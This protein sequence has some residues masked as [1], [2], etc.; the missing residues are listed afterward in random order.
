VRVLV[1]FK[2]NPTDVFGFNFC[3]LME[4]P[5]AYCRSRLAD[6]KVPKV[7]HI[8]SALPKTATGKVQRRDLAALFKPAAK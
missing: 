6:F 5:Q 8:T 1:G 7:I 2:H 4:G 3:A